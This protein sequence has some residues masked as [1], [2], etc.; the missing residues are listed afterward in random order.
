MTSPAGRPGSREDSGLT[1]VDYRCTAGPHDPQVEE[2]HRRFCLAFVRRGSFGCRALGGAFELAP[3]SFFVGYPGDAFTC[4]HD[5]RH[6]GDE[7]LSFDFTP[8]LIEDI[9]IQ[10]RIWRRVAMPALAELTVLGALADAS[11]RSRSSLAPIEAG[12]LLA[13]RFVEISGGRAPKR[14]SP[15]ARDRR[16]A[17]EAALWLEERSGTPARLEDLA[18][19]VELSPFHF[20]RIFSNVHGMTPHQYLVSCRLR[21]AAEMLC[22]DAASITEVAHECGFADLSNFVRTFR[23]AAGV[24]PRGFRAVA[25]GNSNILQ[26]RS[27]APP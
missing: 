25:A 14:L 2:I 21:R 7:C 1:V 16:R 22:A 20:L 11:F 8:E 26:V 6:G 17:V 12:L 9:G 13:A 24:P 15:S 23:R 27:P 18:R 10:P 19:A 3:G 4:T 5:H